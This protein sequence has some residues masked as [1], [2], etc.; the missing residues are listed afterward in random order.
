MLAWIVVVHPFQG[1]GG[2]RGFWVHFVGEELRDDSWRSGVQV[3]D[4]T[5]DELLYF[6]GLGESSLPQ[7]SIHQEVVPQNLVVYTPT[8]S[9]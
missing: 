1:D 2:N 4:A 5:T 8:T 6:L 3:R 9:L 7:S